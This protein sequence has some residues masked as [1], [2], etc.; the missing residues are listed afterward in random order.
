MQAPKKSNQCD[1]YYSL[2]ALERQATASV[3]KRKRRKHGADEA[4]A[5][6]LTQSEQTRRDQKANDR[7]ERD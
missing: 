1:I 7:A 3:C 2:V 5:K 4:P 6:T